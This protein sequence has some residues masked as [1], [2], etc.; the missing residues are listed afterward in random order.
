[1][2]RRQARSYAQR[3]A[4]SPQSAEKQSRQAGRQAGVFRDFK[5]VPA[6]A[7]RLAAPHRSRGASRSCASV[8]TDGTEVS[9]STVRA[10]DENENSTLLLLVVQSL[11]EEQPDTARSIPINQINIETQPH[12]ETVQHQRA[13]DEPSRIA[14]R[15]RR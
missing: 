6:N 5:A 1:V 4:A 8:A 15:T 3:A 9:N 2:S 10:S 14:S 13:T 11:K 12:L 7:Y